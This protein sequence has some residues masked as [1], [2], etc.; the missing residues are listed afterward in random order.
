MKKIKKRPTNLPLVS[1][2]IRTW[3]S[4]STIG[5]TL[6]SVQD[7]SYKNIETLVSDGFSKDD[8]VKIA[9]KFEAKINYADK[10]GDARIKNYK[11]SRGKY[12]LSLDSDQVLDT[13]LVEE[14]VKS[15]EK[16]NL[17][18]LIISERSLITEGTYLEKL[19]AY[20]K[21]VIDKAKDASV[22]FGTACPRF[23]RREFLKNI[24]WPEE[25]SV[26]DDSILYSE[27]LKKGANVG[28]LDSSSIRHHEVTSWIVFARKF[29]RYGKGY[30]KA[31]KEDP[32]TIASRSFPRKAYFSI[33]AMKK[34]HYFLGL[35]LLYSVKSI[36]A[37]LGVLSGTWHEILSRGK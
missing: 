8:S 26:F 12:I 24:R 13:N 36:A 21:Y 25:L 4:G 15:C 14:C 34:P 2:N 29:Y 35:I 17:D 19:I 7:Q 31:F 37:F 16:N 22:K 28:Y 20:D 3:N 23:F 30:L 10:L 9:K 1:I 18:A 27:L 32:A 33:E 6:Q 5:Q 11:L